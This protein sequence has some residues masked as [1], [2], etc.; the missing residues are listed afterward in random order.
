VADSYRELRGKIVA[1]DW[2]ASITA[3]LE[4]HD[5]ARVRGDGRVYWVPP[6][7]VDDVRRLGA[8]LQEVGIDLILCEL[9]PETR[10]VVEQVAHDS[11][12]D[13]LDQLQA[14]AAAFDG[15][16]KPSTYARRLDEYQRLRER[17]ILYR[18]NEPKTLLFVSD[19]PTAKAS[20]QTLESMG[21]AGRWEQAGPAQVSI[22]NSGPPGAAVS[23]RVR[24]PQGRTLA[25]IAPS[26]TVLGIGL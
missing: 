21:L 7:R 2:A 5:A 11:L 14:E 18:T 6:Q 10:T 16:Q 15:T 23:I 13:Q 24:L 4:Y 22:Q 25:S 9:E 1:D 12:A 19:D 17:A 20:A 8:F 3:Y 26:L